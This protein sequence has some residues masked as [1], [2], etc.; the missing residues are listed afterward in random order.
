[1]KSRPTKMGIRS[2]CCLGLVGMIEG[3]G[4]AGNPGSLDPSIRIESNVADID[5]YSIRISYIPLEFLDTNMVWILNIWLQIRS[6][7]FSC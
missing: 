4:S 2:R 6:V 7:P 5:I 3:G 1:M